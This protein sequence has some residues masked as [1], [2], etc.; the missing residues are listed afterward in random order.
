MARLRLRNVEGLSQSQYLLVLTIG[1]VS[2][3][4]LGGLQ[5]ISMTCKPHE[6]SPIRIPSC[7]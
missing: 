2:I 5:V 3:F 4:V 1:C 7:F 6:F